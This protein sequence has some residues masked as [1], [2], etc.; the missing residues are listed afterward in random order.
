MFLGEQI[1][2]GL[3]RFDICAP[4][5]QQRLTATRG[6]IHS[7]LYPSPMSKYL[8][9]Q[10]QLFVRRDARL[11]LFML[12]KSMEYYHELSFRLTNTEPNVSR[13][14]EKNELFDEI[15][16][17]DNLVEIDL[18]TNHV[19]GGHFLLYFQSEPIIFVKSIFISLFLLVDSRIS[20]YAPLVLENDRVTIDPN[21]RSKVVLKRDWGTYRNRA[22]IE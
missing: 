21:R 16:E 12:E 7:P 20:D 6:F 4:G 17:Q 11:R 2:D 13:R 9:C 18:R 5:Y 15:K 22:R 1:T 14:L 19:S 3:P 8:S 10:K